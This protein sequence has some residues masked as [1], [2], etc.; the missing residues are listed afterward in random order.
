MIVYQYGS[1][2]GQN[3]DKSVYQSTNRQMKIQ[4]SQFI[5]IPINNSKSEEANK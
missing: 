2:T 1:K 4:I 5:D 3:L